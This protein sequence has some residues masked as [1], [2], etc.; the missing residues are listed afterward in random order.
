MPW[1]PHWDHDCC[2]SSLVSWVME[3]STP[4]PSQQGMSGSR[5]R[6]A[7]R[8]CRKAQRGTSTTGNA[9]PC[10]C[11][12]LTLAGSAT[13]LPQLDKGERDMRTKN[14]PFKHL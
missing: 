1:G 11:G 9:K 12:A 4:S 8:A 7:R 10:P 2:T 5:G 14:E 3:Q 6:S 13:P